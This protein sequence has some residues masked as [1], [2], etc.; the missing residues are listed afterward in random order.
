MKNIFV[1]YVTSNTDSMR[2]QTLQIL[3]EI[4]NFS[5]Q[6]KRLLGFRDANLQDEAKGS[7]T[8]GPSHVSTIFELL[9][10]NLA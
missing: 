7:T 8:L 6:E 4:L 9:Y 1:R 3:S 10:Y 2:M 5:P